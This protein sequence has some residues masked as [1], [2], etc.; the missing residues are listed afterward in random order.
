MK[1]LRENNASGSTRR[2]LDRLA[3]RWAS[4]PRRPG[5]PQFTR[6]TRRQLRLARQE[7]GVA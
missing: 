2:L 5:V 1:H 7:G 6:I 4:K 3:L